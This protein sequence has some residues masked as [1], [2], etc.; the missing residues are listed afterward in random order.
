MKRQPCCVASYAEGY[1]DGTVESDPYMILWREVKKVLPENKQIVL[2]INEHGELHVCK[3]EVSGDEYYF[4]LN[5]T[6]HQVT[7]VKYWSNL[8]KHDVVIEPPQNA[9]I[10]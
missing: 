8:P 9:I 7:K 3:Y 2:T 6:S 5:E 4:M 1:K 10:I